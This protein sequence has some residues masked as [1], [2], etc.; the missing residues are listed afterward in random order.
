[1]IG[2][3]CD[4]P[5]E[6]FGLLQP[7]QADQ[8]PYQPASAKQERPFP[9]FQAVVRAITIEKTVM[10]QLALRGFDG[11]NHTRIIKRKKP[12]QRD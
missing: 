2:N 8:A 5:Q 10:R 6:I 12:Q 7:F 3:T 4:T 9:A 11:R 1:M